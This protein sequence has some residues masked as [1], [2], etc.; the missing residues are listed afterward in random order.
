MNKEIINN[1]QIDFNKI[2]KDFPT[3]DQEVNGYPLAFLDNAASSQKPLIVIDRVRDFYLNEY[4]NIHRGVHYLSYKATEEY[5]KTRVK[6]KSFLNSQCPQEIIFVRGA[7]EAI[8]LIA[9][10]YGEKYIK[11]D[12]EIIISTLEHH[13]NIVPW[14]MLCQKT[15]AIIKTIPIDQ[16]G[17]LIID[18][19]KKLF[20]SKTKLVAVNH[21]SNSLGTINPVKEMTRIAHENNTKILIDGAQA[22]P[23]MKID[24]QDIDCD[25]YVF[26]GHKVFAP[27][28]IGVLYGKKDI[29]EKMPPYQGGGDMILSVTF[30]KTL[31][32]DLPHR[33]EAGTPNIAGTIGLGAAIDYINKIGFHNIQ[34]QEHKLLTYATNR[35]QEIESLKIIGTSKTK[36]SVIS[37]VLENIHPHDIGTILDKEGVAIR[38]GQ[39][40]TQPVMDFYK[41]PATARASFAF[42]N[43]E[44]DV[45]RLIQAL[46]K[47]IEIM[48]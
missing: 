38:T 21:M 20:T 39:H 1:Q 30:D 33:L 28:G 19:Y 22:V 46:Q 4:S 45:D 18:E 41:I 3:L 32:A 8:N 31:Y 36:G 26:S 23:H 47:T 35:L 29:L 27:T 42:Y 17:E 7:T 14:Q 48:G 10:S 6:I 34:E 9:S 11:K 24:V 37:F 12:D 44:E 40:C 16:K 43:N 2:R 5:E 15:G 13:S 25:F